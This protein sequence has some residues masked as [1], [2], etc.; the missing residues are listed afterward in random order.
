V[1]VSVLFASFFG[2]MRS[3]NMMSLR[4]MRLVTGLFMIPGLVVIGCRAVMLSR[5]LVMLGG[6]PMMFSALFR[7][8]KPSLLKPW[9]LR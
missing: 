3:M 2:V 4:H 8:V 9:H 7:H 1:L 6:F 5:V